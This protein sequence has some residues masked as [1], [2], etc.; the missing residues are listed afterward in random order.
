[1]GR[2][3]SVLGVLWAVLSRFR[4]RVG[5]VLACFWLCCA[6]SGMLFVGRGVGTDFSISGEL[7]VSSVLVSGVEDLFYSALGASWHLWL[8][9]N[10]FCTVLRLGWAAMV[11]SV[12]CLI[13]FRVL[14]SQE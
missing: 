6:C 4:R 7:S 13:C 1:V 2:V 8:L 14:G 5:M 3:Q 11:C 10:I 12:S 9:L